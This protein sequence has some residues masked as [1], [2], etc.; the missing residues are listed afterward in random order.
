ADLVLLLQSYKPD[1]ERVARLRAEM[2]EPVP[3]G[4]DADLLAV[5][6]HKKALAAAELQE[7][8]LRGEFLGKAL[9]YAPRA[10]GVAPSGLGSYPRVRTEY[11]DNLAATKSVTAAL[12]SF[13]A[14]VADNEKGPPNGFLIHAHCQM[15]SYYL[16]LGDIER[17]RASHARAEAIYK[18]LAKRP[19]LA[20]LLP[21][22]SK[23]IEITRGFLLRREGRIEEEERAFRRGGA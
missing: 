4:D 2:E 17:A 13:A 21:G 18:Q 14:F 9:E 8:E 7:L 19:P 6:W 23:Q 5:A 22:W 15:T 20:L 1:P 12:D 11:A 10:K 16:H 3:A